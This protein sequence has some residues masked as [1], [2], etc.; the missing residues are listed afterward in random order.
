M[1]R[2]LLFVATNIEL[3]SPNHQP[4]ES[5]ELSEVPFSRVMDMIA[6][7]EIADSKSS[8]DYDFVLNCTVA[9]DYGRATV[10]IDN[11][12]IRIKPNQIWPFPDDIMGQPMQRPDPI[13]R[14]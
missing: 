10:L 9:K 8:E 13:G 4:D 5:I 14:D 1:K 3:G 7:G 12:E 6:S 2:V 11:R